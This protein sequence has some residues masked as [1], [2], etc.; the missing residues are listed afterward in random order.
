MKF[1][2]IALVASDMHDKMQTSSEYLAPIPILGNSHSIENEIQKYYG[3]R[4]IVIDLYH[5]TPAD[6]KTYGLYTRFENDTR[7]LFD[8]D[9]SSSL[10]TCW[11]RFVGAKELS[12]AILDKESSSRTTDI[13]PLIEMLLNQPQKINISKDIHSEYAAF[14]F[15]IEVLIPYKVNNL[16]IDTKLSSYE[17]AEIIKVPEKMVDLVRA[18]WYQEL[19]RE[20]Y[21]T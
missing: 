11:T 17:I 10:N 15:A 4:R 20:A 6:D 13:V 5:T 1:Q 12:H 21:C 16:V 7:I 3:K 8:I 19:R 9:I 14:C 2:E 18:E